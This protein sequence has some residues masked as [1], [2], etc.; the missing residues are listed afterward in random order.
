MNLIVAVDRKWGIGR[1]NKLLAHLPGDMKFFKKTTMG[2][3]VVMGRKTLESMPGGKGLPGRVNIVLTRNTEYQAKDAQVVHTRDEL[4]KLL[5][6]YD[7][8]KVFI[9][10]GGSIYR[11]FYKYCSVC[12]ITKINA[13]FDADTFMVNLDE[14]D[15]F[16]LTNVSPEQEDNGIKYTF[17]TYENVR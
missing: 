12:Y 15:D 2:G 1:D 10:G 14:D 9:I 16:K 13:E 5:E 4:M 6:Q 17:C 8:Q 3:V 7:D 11:E